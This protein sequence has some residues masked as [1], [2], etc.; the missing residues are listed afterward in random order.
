MVRNDHLLNFEGGQSNKANSYEICT[1][2]VLNP[3]CSKKLSFQNT[4]K[5]QVTTPISLLYSLKQNFV[6]V[7]CNRKTIFKLQ[8][9]KFRHKV[10][11]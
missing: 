8:K 2:N 5:I 9:L 7:S 11:N 6:N 1:F 3:I 4:D 10:P